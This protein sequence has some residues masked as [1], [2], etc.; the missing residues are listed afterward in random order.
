MSIRTNITET[1]RRRGLSAADVAR[2]L[3][4]FPSNISAMD[5]GRRSVSL[6]LLER[7][8]N[9]LGCSVSELLETKA[10]S[11]STLFPSRTMKRLRERDESSRDGSDKT[12]THRALLV[13][14]RHYLRGRKR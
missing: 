3:K 8:A 7:V 1:A 13:W 2:K 11:E 4:L 9:M 12:W 14:Q 10:V 6:H 5:R